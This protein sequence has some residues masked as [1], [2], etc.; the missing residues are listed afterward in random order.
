[1]KLQFSEIKDNLLTPKVD[2]RTEVYNWGVIDNAYPSTMEYLLNASVTAKNCIDKSSKAI[3]G[4]GVKD[5]HIIVN[6]KGH[7]LNDVIRTLARE[8][9]KHNN[10]FL[11]VGYN[12][13][14]EVSSIEAIPSKNVRV[15]KKDDQDYNGKYVVYNNWD[16]AQGKIDPNAFQV[17]DRF[18]PLKE[19]VKGQ[20]EH[21]SGISKYKGQ[22]VHIQKYMNEIYSLADGDCVIQD[23]IAEI[24]A[25]EFKMKGTSDGFLNT[26]IMAVKP[27]ST[28][29]ERSAFKRDLDS[30]RGAKN[31]NSIILLEAPDSST[32]LKDNIL[33]QDLTSTHN[34]KLFEYTENSVEKA[35]AKAFNV[36]I[37]LINPAENGLFGNS[38]EMYKV[39]QDIMWEEAEEERG[40]IEEVLTQIMNNY[41]EPIRGRIDI[42]RSHETASPTNTEE[43]NV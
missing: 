30:L 14:G 8:Y 19:V 17:V 6:K 42:I 25:A 26:K 18:N 34:D 27:F 9:R 43:D 31:A 1:M 15:G 13:L 40:K 36:P 5:G 37:A 11:W 23:M 32:D 16:G 39:I 20:I 10:A 35:V 21:A 28:D 29:E 41:R 3:M 12:L 33:L 2:K 38:G 4:K 7:S 22:I 24:N